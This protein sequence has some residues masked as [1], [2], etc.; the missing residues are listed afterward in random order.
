MVIAIAKALKVDILQAQF[1]SYAVAHNKFVFV[2]F[3][4]L[5]HK[6]LLLNKI[7]FKKSLLVEEVF[8]DKSNSQIYLNDRARLSN[9]DAPTSILCERHLNELTSIGVNMDSTNI[10]GSHGSVIND[11]YSTINT[12][13]EYTQPSTSVTKTNKKTQKKPSATNNKQTKQTTLTNLDY[14]H[15]SNS[16]GATNHTVASNNRRVR[17]HTLKRKADENDNTKQAKKPKYTVIQ[18]VSK[19]FF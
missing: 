7:R 16:N 9:N 17:T 6:Q 12:S 4:N 19:F 15:T 2:H 13:L 5:K 14:I 3:F 10:S 18:Q 11:S 1:S 8:G